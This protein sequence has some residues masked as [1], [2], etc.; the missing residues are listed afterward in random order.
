MRATFPACCASAAKD[1]GAR[2]TARTT[3]SPIRR[4]DTSVRGWLAG[5]LAERHDGH[6]HGRVAPRLVE[7]ALFDHSVCRPQDRWRDPQS[8][9][10]PGKSAT[11]APLAN[12]PRGLGL[13]SGLMSVRSSPLVMSNA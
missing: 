10:P 13:P 1:A 11:F 9:G 4:M 3:A 8:E 6:H 7:H 2:L 12:G 5:S